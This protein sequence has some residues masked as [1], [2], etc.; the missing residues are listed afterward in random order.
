MATKKDVL[1]DFLLLRRD[2]IGIV[3]RVSGHELELSM[4]EETASE[5]NENTGYDTIF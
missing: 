2:A 5:R 1:A 3:E 4:Y